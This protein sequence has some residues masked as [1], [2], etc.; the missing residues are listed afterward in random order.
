M[1]SMKIKENFLT[2]PDAPDYEINSQLIVR[3][4]SNGK[5]LK[6]Y[7]RPDRNGFTANVR[8]DKGKHIA[9]DTKTFRRQAVTAVKDNHSH[10]DWWVTLPSLNFLYE[11][12]PRGILRNVKSKHIIKRFVLCGYQFFS[13]RINNN[14]K[15]VSLNSLLWE[16][17]GIIAEKK[18]CTHTPPIANV[19]SDGSTVLN[20]VSLLDTAAF[21]SKRVFRSV[22]TILNKLYREHPNEIYGWNISYS[23]SES[24]GE[25]YV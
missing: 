18:K 15:H 17:H 11:I 21:L 7:K 3:K 22:H 1:I 8:D 25:H 6:S 14:P 2:I 9:R 4:K 12:N 19:I 24:V 10:I 13:V 16:A 23:P 20:F 5:I